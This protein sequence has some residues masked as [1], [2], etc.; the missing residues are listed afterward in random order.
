M[1]TLTQADID[2][3]QE[4]GYVLVGKVLSDEQ[5]AQ[6]HAIIAERLPAQTEKTAFMV[7]LRKDV[8]VISEM[9]SQ[10]PIA[11]V[12]TTLIGPNVRLWHDQFVIKFPDKTAEGVFPW[13]QDNGYTEKIFP[14]NNITLWVALDKVSVEN[15][16]VWVVPGSHKKGRLDHKVNGSS[17]HMTLDVEGD[18]IP[19]EMEAGEAIAFSA[20]TLHRSKSNLSSNPRRA[21]FLEYCDADTHVDGEPINKRTKGYMVDSVP[22]PVIA[23]T[24][25]LAD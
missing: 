21:L 15:G 7:N 22:C 6:L 19:A 25:T 10:G 1:K 17:W 4:N 23:G 13:H 20:Y 2:F 5:L 18:G 12:M 11:Q 16:C 24:S 3:Y 14:D 9:G 8:P